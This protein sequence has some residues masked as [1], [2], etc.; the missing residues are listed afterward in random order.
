SH[1]DIRDLHSFPTRRSS[2]L[3]ISIGMNGMNETSP[4][5]LS[6]T[7]TILR[8]LCGVWGMRCRNNGMIKYW[9]QRYRHAWQLLPIVWTALGRLALRITKCRVIIRY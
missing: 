2:D 8:Y 3:T 7:E 5:I 1:R 9:G 6:A 4:H